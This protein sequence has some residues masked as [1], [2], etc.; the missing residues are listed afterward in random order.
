MNRKEIKEL[1]IMNFVWV[2]ICFGS[3]F[4]AATRTGNVEQSYVIG[5]FMLMVG[6]PFINRDLFK[7]TVKKN[8]VSV[9]TG[10]GGGR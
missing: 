3:I 7:M 5:L 9:A 4:W 6:A 2:V 8:D 10:E 1:I